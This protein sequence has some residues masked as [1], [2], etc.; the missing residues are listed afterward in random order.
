[1]FTVKIF[2]LCYRTEYFLKTY[3]GS[4]TQG[5]KYKV[6]EIF[7]KENKARGKKEERQEGGPVAD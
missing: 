5:L 2:Q 6:E 3:G 4:S 7:Q 1:M